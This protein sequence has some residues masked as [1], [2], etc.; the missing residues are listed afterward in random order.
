[1]N[2]KISAPLSIA[3]IA[4]LALLVSLY[5]VT[6]SRNVNF[7]AGNQSIEMERSLQKSAN[8][9]VHAFQGST[10]VSV[11]K[12]MK[13]GKIFLQ[14]AKEDTPKLPMKDIE[15]FQLIDPTPEIE[16]DIDSSS[17]KEPVKLSISGFASL[18][19]GTS[20]VCISYKDKIFSPYITN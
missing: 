8:C 14:V 17:E 7:I 20:L 12:I 10:E 6:K 13:N 3:L 5:T 11:W 15:N 18:C 9:K 4:V 19:D 2:K 1:M 16:K